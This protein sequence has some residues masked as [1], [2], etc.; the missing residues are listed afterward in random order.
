MILIL[1]HLGCSS[2][3]DTAVD[4]DVAST[5]DNW[6]QDFTKQMPIVPLFK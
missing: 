5:Y 2:G 4:C 6:A 3:K 1:L